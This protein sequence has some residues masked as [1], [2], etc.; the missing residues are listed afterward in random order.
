[1]G[2]GR[3]YLLPNAPPRHALHASLLYQEGALWDSCAR[4]EEEKKNAAVQIGTA[5][6]CYACF[7]FQ[8]RK[9]MSQAAAP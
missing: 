8:G 3:F 2:R 5:A 7:F 4:C 9:E 1:M 6:Y